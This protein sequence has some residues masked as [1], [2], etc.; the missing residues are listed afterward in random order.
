[1]PA[2]NNFDYQRPGR[3][4]SSHLETIYPALFRKV[5]NVSPATRERIDTPDGDFLDLE[6]R[7][8]GQG[9]LVIIQHGLEGRADR[10]YMLG[11]AKCFFEN[12]FDVL[13]WSFRGCSGE[14]NRTARFY[15]SGAT[16]D[17][18]LVVDAA[19]GAYDDLSLVGFS[20]GGNL[21][22]KYLGEAPR[23]PRIKRGVAISAPLDLDK[24][25]DKLHSAQG[26]IYE[27]RFLRHLKAKV[28][29]K[30]RNMPDKINLENLSKVKTLRDF[31][32]YYTAPLHGFASATDYYRK[33]SSKFFLA[34]IQV[35]TLV[36]N[37][38]ND[39]ILSEESLD[40]SLT[41]HLPLVHLE[42]TAHGGHVGF[43][44]KATQTYYW[45]EKRALEFCLHH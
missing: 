16:D 5:G 13:T 22:L 15:H 6:W 28:A 19:I 34:G 9:K 36:L 11:M 30:A 7:R 43:F 35:P 32:D 41:A 26:L 14:M 1:M 44:E 20:L 39:P 2:K 37:A 17:L 21:T 38:K 3:F 29:E 12:G 42:T 40:H 33:C 24:G 31:D 23:D 18:G 27:K 10:P 45:S 25:V 4:F 8:Q